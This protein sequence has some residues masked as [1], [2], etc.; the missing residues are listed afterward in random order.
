MFADDTKIWAKITGSQDALSLQEDLDELQTW[1]DKWML[2]LN[3]EKCKV[4]HIKHNL[5]TRYSITEN[6]KSV[7]LQE[8]NQ[9]R[10]LGVLV[11]ADLKPSAQCEAAANKARLIL[12]MVHRQFK[13]LNEQH[14]LITY[15]TY[16]HPH[17]EYCIQA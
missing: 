6:G 10:D 7:E 14:F 15:K 11:T 2:R 9:E 17:L 12:G 1:T 13:R 8:S 4:M 16:V 5:K 3:T